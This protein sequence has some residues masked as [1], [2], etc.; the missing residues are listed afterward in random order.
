MLKLDGLPEHKRMLAERPPGWIDGM[1]TQLG[2]H[3][4][5]KENCAY[6]IA[7]LMSIIALLFVHTL[8]SYHKGSNILVHSQFNN[9]EE[10]AFVFEVTRHGARA[11][12][13]KN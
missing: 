5:Y 11:P 1:L 12:F 13:L 4:E 6:F 8:L 7:V 10:I 9:K 2:V 3:S